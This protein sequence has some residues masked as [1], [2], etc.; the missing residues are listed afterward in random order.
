MK[1]YL[2]EGVGTFILVLLLILVSNNNTGNLIPLAYGAILLSLSYAGGSISGAHYNPA[3]SLGVLISGKLE[4]WDLPYYWIAQILA[5]LLAAFMAAFLI[6]CSGNTD[7]VLQSHSPLCVLFAEGLGTFTLT[8]VYL[9]VATSSNPESK[10]YFGLAIGFTVIAGVFAFNGISDATFNPA[11]SIA[12][13]ITDMV[14]WND[15]WANLLGTFLGAAAGAS[16]YKAIQ[17]V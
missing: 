9:S 12:M 14:S 11:I 1:K 4:R 2:T 3:I 17:G 6:R 8:Y 15:I 5:S 10:T 16:V 13:A 7:M